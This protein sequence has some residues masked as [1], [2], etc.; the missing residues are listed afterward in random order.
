M[1]QA[2]A[3]G[4]KGEML[5]ADG[6]LSE[7]VEMLGEKGEGIYATQLWLENSGLQAKYKRYYKEAVDPVYLTFVALGYDAVSL[8]LK[9]EELVEERG[10]FTVTPSL[11]DAL[12]QVSFRGL[13]GLIEFNADRVTDKVEELVVIKDGRLRKVEDEEIVRAQLQ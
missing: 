5:S 1:K 12:A 13:T 4:Y 9:T 11:R 2:K 6:V 3:L 7:V 10:D 8:V